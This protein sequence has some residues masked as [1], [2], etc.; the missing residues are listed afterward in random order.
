LDIKVCQAFQELTEQMEQ[1][2]LMDRTVLKDRLA[3]KVYR[4]LMEQMEQMEQMVTM[5]QLVSK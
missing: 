4:E 1:M 3:H 5:H 2:V